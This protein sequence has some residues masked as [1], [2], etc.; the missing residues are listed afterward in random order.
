[1]LRNG[2]HDI[3]VAAGDDEPDSRLMQETAIEGVLLDG[4]PAR[5]RPDE[6]V[7]RLRAMGFAG[8]VVVTL[9]LEERAMVGPV[10]AAGADRVVRR[11]PAPSEVLAAFSGE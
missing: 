7:R 9:A 8:R 4:R 5:S 6:I 10:V 1:V 11:P 2:G 3:V